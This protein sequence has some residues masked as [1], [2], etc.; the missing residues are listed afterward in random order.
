[1]NNLQ[2]SLHSLSSEV[3][4]NTGSQNRQ[5]ENGIVLESRRLD[6]VFLSPCYVESQDMAQTL[7]L[8]KRAA[9]SKKEADTGVA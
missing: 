7:L 1:L 3:S 5:Q 8:L 2:S 6:W 4:D 9:L